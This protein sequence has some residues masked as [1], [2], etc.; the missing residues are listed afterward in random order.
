MPA[1]IK[2]L[3]FLLIGLYA[4][5]QWQFSAWRTRR[6][7]S[8][9]SRPLDDPPLEAVVRR[10]GR[11]VELP[12]LKA[13]VYDL[14]VFNGLASPDGGIYITRGVMD[15]YRLGEVSA[16]E[17]GSILAHELG[18]VALGHSRRRMVDWTGQNALRLG[19]ALVLNRLIPFVGAMIADVLARLVA[20]RLSRRDEFEADAYAAALMRRAGVDPEAQVRMFEKLEHMAGPAGGLAWLASHPPLGARIEAVQALHA[21]WDDADAAPLPGA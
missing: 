17:I 14:P 5:V 2:F 13:M 20:S 9:R 21:R 1:M 3:P 16:E 18:H 4:L 8:A 12:H 7:L 19:L 11:A 6:E 10:L 15:K